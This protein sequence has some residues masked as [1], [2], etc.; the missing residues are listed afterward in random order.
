MENRLNIQHAFP[1]AFKAMYGLSAILENT[2]LTK[3][4]KELIKVRA[5]Q[6]NSCAFCPD[7][8]TKDALKY[9]ETAQRLFLL[10]AWRETDLLQ[11]QKK[12]LAR[13]Y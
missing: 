13:Y 6:I 7:M 12:S 9:G 2:Q 3:I 5:S 10:N 11:Q 4:Q 8:H 1:A